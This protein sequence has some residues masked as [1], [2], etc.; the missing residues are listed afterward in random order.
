M[1]YGFHLENLR[2][3]PN[4][5]SDGK[6]GYD[7]QFKIGRNRYFDLRLLIADTRLTF[8]S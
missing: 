2:N 4:F 7:E 1:A 3:F 8:D 6:N 5:L